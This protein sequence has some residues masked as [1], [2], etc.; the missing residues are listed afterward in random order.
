MIQVTLAVV[1]MNVVHDRDLNLKRY[2]QY[3]EK[4]AEALVER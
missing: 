1:S 4:G 3:I 2:I